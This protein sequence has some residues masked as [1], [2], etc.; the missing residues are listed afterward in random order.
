[1]ARVMGGSLTPASASAGG[2]VIL[3]GEHAVVHGQP[4][5][6]AGIAARVTVAVAPRSG[7][8]E[9]RIAAGDLGADPRVRAAVAEARRLAGVPQES[10]LDVVIAGDLPVAVGLGS[11]AALSVAL[12]RAL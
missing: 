5:L 12:L 1:M 2:K 4:A 3:L 9:I 6:V 10:G 7:P 8:E 11:S